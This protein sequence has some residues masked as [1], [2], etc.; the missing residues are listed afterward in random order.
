M[1]DFNREYAVST[2][3]S[4]FSK[5]EELIRTIIDNEMK[6]AAGLLT[7]E[8]ACYLVAQNLGKGNEFAIAMDR[9]VP[10]GASP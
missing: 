4:L 9:Y 5:K 2:M 6:R 3:A 7:Y 10:G 8:A 1:T